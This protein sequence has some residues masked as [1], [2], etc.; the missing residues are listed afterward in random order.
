MQVVENKGSVRP[1]RPVRRSAGGPCARVCAREVALSDFPCD[2]LL[3]SDRS[4]RSDRPSGNHGQTSSF[5]SFRGLTGLTK[6]H[7]ARLVRV[8]STRGG[9]ANRQICR[10]SPGDAR[11]GCSGSE[12]RG[13]FQGGCRYTD[14]TGAHVSSSLTVS[15][16]PQTS[17]DGLKLELR[18]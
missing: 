17:H 9:V 2:F 14:M 13:S 10:F 3:R 4:D 11:P 18:R 5:L 6:A 7:A 12:T 16:E 1:V 15:E 8:G